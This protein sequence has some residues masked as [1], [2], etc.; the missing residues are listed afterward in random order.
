MISNHLKRI[1]PSDIDSNIGLLELMPLFPSQDRYREFIV[2]KALL[3]KANGLCSCNKTTLTPCL[4]ASYSI[5]N[6][7][8]KSN[9]DNTW[10]EVNFPFKFLNVIQA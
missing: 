9:K 7:F 4:E 6:S 1:F 3:K 8:E 5:T 2:V 10:E